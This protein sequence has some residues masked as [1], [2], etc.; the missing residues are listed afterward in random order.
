MYFPSRHFPVSMVT[1]DKSRHLTRLQPSH[2][3]YLCQQNKLIDHKAQILPL[4]LG[5]RKQLL[6]G[7]G[8]G[9]GG[10]LDKNKND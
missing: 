3:F 8:G 9:G 1:T 2:Y 10:G 6:G 4:Q 7:G 5:P